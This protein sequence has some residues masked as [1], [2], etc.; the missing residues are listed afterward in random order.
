MGFKAR[1]WVTGGIKVCADAEEVL[2]GSC[3]CLCSCVCVCV[4]VQVCVHVCVYVCVCVRE[5]E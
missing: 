4:C 3:D 5:R 2:G 1:G